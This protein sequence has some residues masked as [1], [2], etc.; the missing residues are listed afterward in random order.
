[1]FAYD[2]TTERDLMLYIFMSI[3]AVT[4]GEGVKVKVWGPYWGDVGTGRRYGGSGE[5]NM[6]WETL[7]RGQHYIAY[8]S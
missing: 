6:M 4:E 7:W 3:M 5:D 8:L 2:D 1:M